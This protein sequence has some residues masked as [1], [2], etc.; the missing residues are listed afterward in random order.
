MSIHE[1]PRFPPPAPLF[2]RRV[3]EKG[4]ANGSIWDNGH[5]QDSPLPF[6]FV[7]CQLFLSLGSLSTHKISSIPVT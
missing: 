1:R 4:V 7:S 6:F 5:L 3:G 2:Y